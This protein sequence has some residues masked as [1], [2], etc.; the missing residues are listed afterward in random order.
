MIQIHKNTLAMMRRPALLAA[1]ALSMTLTG[2]GA[3]TGL[4]ASDDFACPMTPGVSC[5][6]LSDTYEDS[7]KGRTVDKIE[8]DK[9]VQEASKDLPDIEPEEKD[10]L[11]QEPAVRALTEAPKNPDQEP[12]MKGYKLVPETRTSPKRI[13]EVLVTIWIAPWTD[14][15]GDFHEGEV[16]HA[17]A[18]DARWAAARRRA[19]TAGGQ[20]AVVQLPFHRR[21][22]PVRTLKKTAA[23]TP[24]ADTGIGEGSRNFIEA[25]KAAL[26]GTPYDPDVIAGRMLPSEEAAQ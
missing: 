9:V 24:V 16:I 18:F 4:N 19:E 20:A 21:P 22:A 2:C 13:P 25:Q 11:V 5:R 1:A 6:S 8:R 23:G 3:L 17:K 14:D 7:V 10:P 26:K 15:E 12:K